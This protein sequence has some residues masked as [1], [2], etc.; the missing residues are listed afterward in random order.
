MTKLP[1]DLL[2]PDEINEM[3][4]KCTSTR[5]RAL[6]SVLYESGCRVGELGRLTWK[7]AVFDEY[8]VRLYIHDKK[9]NK[10]RY[11]RLTMSREYLATYRNDYPGSAST[12]ENFIFVNIMGNLKGLPVTY[13]GVV[14]I[15]RTAGKRA[16]ITKKIRPHLF[17]SSRITHMVAQ[18]YQES[19][20]K[21]SMW[22][23]INTDMFEV[24]VRLAEKDIDREFLTKSGITLPE[25][26]L[27]PT[28]PRPCVRCH[29]INGPT[30]S[31]CSKCGAPLTVDL[32]DEVRRTEQE[33]E[34][35]PEYRELLREFEMRLR[36]IPRLKS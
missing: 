16:K 22:G 24:Y 29:E 28:A 20:I 36:D 34:L 33:I 12:D 17:R 27:V 19:V 18:N 25:E 2:T 9:T 1:G 31:Y 30:S 21:K 4:K 11:S 10:R 7:D 32:T 5:D 8:G 14:K 13:R 15:L 26:S 35:L 23:N 6:I 3:L